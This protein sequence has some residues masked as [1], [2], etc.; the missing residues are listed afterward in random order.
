MLEDSVSAALTLLPLLDGEAIDDKP[1]VRLSCLTLL[2]DDIDEDENLDDGDDVEAVVVRWWAVAIRM[3]LI[4]SQ[5]VSLRSLSLSVILVTLHG[6]TAALCV[7]R[8]S[9][10]KS[11]DV[12]D[13]KRDDSNEP[14]VLACVAVE[15]PL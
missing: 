14:V 4:T 12:L 6:A 5:P 8:L 2:L 1:I 7:Y 3:L 11:K 9:S 15:P 13:E 10:F